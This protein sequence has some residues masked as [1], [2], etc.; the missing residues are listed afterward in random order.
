MQNFWVKTSQNMK[1]CAPT[2]SEYLDTW[3][4]IQIYGMEKM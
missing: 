4:I 2:W 1:S 3:C